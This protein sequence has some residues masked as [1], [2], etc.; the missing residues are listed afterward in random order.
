M[1]YLYHSINS[2]SEFEAFG[3]V[4]AVVNMRLRT[5]GT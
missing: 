1:G 2:S 4:D 5:I 3:V